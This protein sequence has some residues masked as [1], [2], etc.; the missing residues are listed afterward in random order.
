MKPYE[1]MVTYTP[2]TAWI[3]RK[4]ALIWLSLYAGILGG[5]TYLA[6]LYF[7]NLPGM[8]LG[9]LII[10]II[11]SGLHL[12]HAERPRRLWRMM[13][14]PQTSW[15]S[16][17]LILTTLFIIFGALQIAL[18]LWQAGSG[19]ETIFSILAGIC[20]FGI[21]VYTGFTMSSVGGIPLWNSALLPV[22]FLVWALLTGLE[23]VAAIG[24][25]GVDTRTAAA[26]AL[27]LLI[28][29]IF[30]IVTYLSVASYGEPAVRESARAM[31]RGR[32]AA[33]F[34]IGIMLIG[35]VIPFAVSFHAY[36]VGAMSPWLSMAM[37]VCTVVGGLSLT[38]A[39]LKAGLYS[40]LPASGN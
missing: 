14:R 16:R 5:G 37:V 7:G 35:T 17:G 20:A 40:P 19:A 3:E 39:A 11:K 4:G 23:L 18:S 24:D 27:A 33:V 32:M 2:Q 36:R 21:V 25:A 12:I 8:I 13:L 30:S 31:M 10:L 22:L 6:A 1:W 9:W 15:I 26:G 34:F 29:S 28:A 38:Y